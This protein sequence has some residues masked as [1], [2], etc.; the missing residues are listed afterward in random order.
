MTRGGPVRLLQVLPGLV[1]QPGRVPGEAP[2][3][4]MSR[5]AE[6]ERGF[7]PM[8]EDGSQQAIIGRYR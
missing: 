8:R 4:V 6:L 7:Q 5:Q 1:K 3:A 2:Y